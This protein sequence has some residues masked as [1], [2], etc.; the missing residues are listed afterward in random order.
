[1]GEVKE[2]QPSEFV[3]MCNQYE[4]RK[5]DLDKIMNLASKTFEMIQEITLVGRD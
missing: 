1:M 4:E 5:T 3:T 2:I